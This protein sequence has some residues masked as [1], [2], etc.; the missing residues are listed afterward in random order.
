MTKIKREL[1]TRV[2][3]LVCTALLIFCASRQLRATTLT[4]D[5]VEPL[6]TLDN[7]EQLSLRT[8]SGAFSSTIQPPT[9]NWRIETVDSEGMVGKY[10]SLALDDSDRPHISY[11]GFE[12]LKHAW[13]DG[14]VWHVETV[15]SVGSW[16]SSTSLALDGSG[17]PHIGYSTHY[18]DYGIGYAWYDG[19]TWHIETVDSSGVV[20]LSASLALDGLD[21]PHIGYY[22]KSESSDGLKYAYRDDD[23]WHIETVDSGA[24]YV[25]VG[26]ATSLALD[27]SGRPHISYRGFRQVSYEDELKHAWHDGT[28]WHVET[29]DSSEKMGG[30]TSL[31][32]DASD[33]SRISYFDEINEIFKY[34]WYDGT[35]WHIEAVDSNMGE[36]A[37]H[38]SLALDASERPHISYF[39]EEKNEIKYAWRNG[40]SWHTERAV[41]AGYTSWVNSLALDK[42]GWPHVAYGSGHDDL[43]YAQLLPPLLDKRATPG[44]GLHNNDV[45]TYTLVLSGSAVSVQL[46]DPLP[47]N[48]DY[49]TDSVTSPAIY[50]PTVRAV[51]WQGT[52]PTDTVQTIH[53]QVTPNSSEIGENALSPPIVNTAWLTD[54]AHG[55]SVSA[56]IIV[57]GRKG[58]LPLVLRDR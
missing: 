27:K 37:A 9:G 6:N 33:R 13:H 22:L 50:S 38:S 5:T 29:V 28:T 16:D 3:A 44:D 10:P 20:G 51:V 41:E 49:I 42:D 48:V 17:R 14:S 47:E 58:F 34:A 32:L 2:V 8:F 18:P 30:N 4:A 7:I 36:D 15:D 46:W 23:I 55:K 43:R 57:N 54:T 31:V 19:A 52:L 35:D 40:V 26:Y 25:R 12:G 45:L 53:F 39:D 11:C 21:Q 24:P 56:M 1:L